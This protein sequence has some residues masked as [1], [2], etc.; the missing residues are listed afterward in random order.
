MLVPRRLCV[1]S[2][3]QAQRLQE[4]VERI[5]AARLELDHRLWLFCLRGLAG[6]GKL[7]RRLA[8]SC[9]FRPGLGL[10][11]TS[12]FAVGVDPTTS[13]FFSA[14]MAIRSGDGGDTVSASA[15]ASGGTS[16]GKRWTSSR[17][18]FFRV[19]PNALASSFSCSNGSSSL[20]FERDGVPSSMA[21]RTPR[22]ITMR[23]IL[24]MI[25]RF[26]NEDA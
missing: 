25:L 15:I 2:R 20:G 18:P 6:I 19:S 11:T 3:G 9:I 26:R 1:A 24:I 10:F 21:M 12:F 16:C 17:S 7:G 23:Q 8:G 4:L 5:W 14:S 13:E 22:P